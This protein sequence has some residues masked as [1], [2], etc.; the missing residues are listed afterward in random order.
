[1]NRDRMRL[2][3][4]PLRNDRSMPL[5]SVPCFF[6][7]KMRHILNFEAVLG[8]RDILVSIR[9]RGSGPLT[10]GSTSY[11]FLPKKNFFL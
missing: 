3:L 9:I 4:T 2:L 10:N 6:R 1:M 5:S 8:I 7:L 11:S